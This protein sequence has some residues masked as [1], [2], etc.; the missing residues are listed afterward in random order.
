MKEFTITL[1][2][3]EMNIIETS[4]RSAMTKKMDEMPIP[5]Y[6]WSNEERETLT[7]YVT[8]WKKV[9]DEINK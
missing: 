8:L 3:E 9:M 1:T 7:K 5:S 4:M 6:K 2:E